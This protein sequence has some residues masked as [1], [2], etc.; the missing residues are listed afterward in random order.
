MRRMD[1]QSPA[2]RGSHCRPILTGFGLVVA[3]LSIGVTRVTRVIHQVFGTQTSPNRSGL[4][5][6]RRRV[7]RVGL[8]TASGALVGGVALAG[9]A[10]A[11]PSSTCAEIAPGFSCVMR[12]RIGAVERYLHDAPG[13]IGIVLADRTTG[14]VWRNANA[15][16]DYPAA[17]TMKLA[18]MTDI[19]LRANVGSIDLTGTDHDEMYNA[20]YTSNDDDATALWDK[21]EDG[22]FLHRIRAFGMAMRVLH[23]PG[24][25]VGLHVLLG[26][27]S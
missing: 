26:R 8:V 10:D 14:A 21:Y 6:G 5:A 27:G 24:A 15:A 20:L 23:V 22:T 3:A 12:D 1:D 16:A 17:S 13:S 25:D 18:M 9:L 4:R 7:L 11:S 19:L 2:T